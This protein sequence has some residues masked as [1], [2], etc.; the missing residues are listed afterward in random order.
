MSANIYRLVD[1]DRLIGLLKDIDD[2][3]SR[4]MYKRV[5]GK[6]VVANLPYLDKPS[7]T[8]HSYTRDADAELGAMMHDAYDACLEARAHVLTNGDDGKT[9]VAGGV[10]I[11]CVIRQHG[12]DESLM[13]DIP[14]DWLRPVGVP[15]RERC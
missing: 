4:H 1:S 7:I 14:E 13:E 8:M 6:T 11:D 3:C 2:Y 9:V 15:C 5:V 10:S 12:R